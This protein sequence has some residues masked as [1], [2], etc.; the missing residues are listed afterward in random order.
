MIMMLEVKHLALVEAIAQAGTVTRAAERLHLT[1]SALSHQLL[2]LE[3]R[4]GLQFFVRLGRRMLP[5]P[6]GERIL[7]SARRVLDD[8][9]RTEDDLRG[10]ATGVK[11]VLRLCTECNTGYHWLP[12]LLRNFLHFLPK[13]RKLLSS[14]A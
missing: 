5:T 8:L 3:A 12:P 11:G 13:V 7:A 2:D 1:Q 9:G 14:Y 10:M 4:A 6:A